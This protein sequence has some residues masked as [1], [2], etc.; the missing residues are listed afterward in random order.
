MNIVVIYV[1]PTPFH[2]EHHE[3][4]A[5][6]FAGS[7]IANDPGIEHSLI[8]VSNG[9]PPCSRVEAMFSA[10]PGFKGFHIHD[11]TGW[12]LGAF[13]SAARNIP[14]DMMV[15]F[16]G[17]A[18]LKR[19][20]WLKRMHEAL[21]KH[22]GEY[23]YGAFATPGPRIHIR[24]TGFWC[25]PHVLLSY[26]TT[27]DRPEQRYEFEH[28]VSNFTHHCLMNGRKCWM[29]TWSGEYEYP[30]WGLVPNAYGQGNHSECLCADRVSDLVQPVK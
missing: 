8:V 20:G 10:V 5:E 28:G 19:P 11:D 24:T 12:D 14:A 6:R 29:V 21:M 18:Y 26:P 7:Y 13:Q 27:I 30:S 23:L 17:N 9:G 22:G 2:G 15:F 3:H 25:M 4:L 16:G 1:C